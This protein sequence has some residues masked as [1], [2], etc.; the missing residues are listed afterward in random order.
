M[1]QL[2][3]EGSTSNTDDKK[4]ND[5]NGFKKNAF[6]AVSDVRSSCVV[7]TLRRCVPQLHIIIAASLTLW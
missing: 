5:G 6:N 3:Q 4:C 2:N 7:V 1:G